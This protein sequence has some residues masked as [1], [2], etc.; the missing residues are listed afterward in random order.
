MTP[1][2]LKDDELLTESSKLDESV[3]RVVACDGKVETSTKNEQDDLQKTSTS[4]CDGTIHPGTG[5]PTPTAVTFRECIDQTSKSTFASN[6]LSGAKSN[7]MESRNAMTVMSPIT[8][9]F[10]RMLGAGTFPTIYRY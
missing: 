6:L 10:E 5:S 2:D 9:C 1:E 8:M 3:T 4:N 7:V